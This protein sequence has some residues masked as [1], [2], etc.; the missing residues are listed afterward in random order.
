MNKIFHTRFSKKLL[1]GVVYFCYNIIVRKERVLIHIIYEGVQRMDKKLIESIRDS[2][3]DFLHDEHILTVHID[4]STV[5]NEK[6][7][8]QQKVYVRVL[9]DEDAMKGMKFVVFRGDGI[10]KYRLEHYENGIT[11]VTYVNDIEKFGVNI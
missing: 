6:M 11:Y 10:F 9:I 3:K 7:E 8:G 2:L 1:T 5:Y 4:T